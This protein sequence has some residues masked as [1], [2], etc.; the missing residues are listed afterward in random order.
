MPILNNLTVNEV[1]GSPAPQKQ[2]T[3]GVYTTQTEIADDVSYASAWVS[4]GAIMTAEFGLVQEI[5]GG[6]VFADAFT[7]CQELS[8]ADFS[9]LQT[10]SGYESCYGMFS[11]CPMLTSISFPVLTTISG[12]RACVAMFSGTPLTTV[13]ISALET[14]GNGSCM[15]MFEATEITTLT[16]ASLTTVGDTGLAMV[17]AGCSYLTTVSFPALDPLQCGTDPLGDENEGYAF[18][19]C[20][21]L[22]AIHFPQ[23]TQS[24]VSQWAGYAEKWGATNA[25]IYFDL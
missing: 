5:S 24:D 10:I 16:F 6:A 15:N 25:T 21:S 2:I 18:A 4:C 22:T 9:S 23:G 11:T 3:M 7:D 19:D 14:I 1:G 13:D 12:E 20:N 8:D 17:C